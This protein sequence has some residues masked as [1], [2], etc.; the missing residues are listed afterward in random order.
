LKKLLG[1]QE[2]IQSLPQQAQRFASE[3]KESWNRGFQAK[4]DAWKAKCETAA[5]RRRSAEDL[6][7]TPVRIPELLRKEECVRLHIH[8]SLRAEMS[9][10]SSA[11]E[12]SFR[13][14]EGRIAAANKISREISSVSSLSEWLFAASSQPYST[15]ENDSFIHPSIIV[16]DRKAGT[17]IPLT[18]EAVEA[19]PARLLISG[20][21]GMGKTTFC[22]WSVMERLK[23]LET[24]EGMIV[25]VYVPA[26]QLVHRSLSSFEEFFLFSEQM[27]SLWHNRNSKSIGFRIYIDGLD[28][29]PNAVF[30]QQV[31][32]MAIAET[33]KN[34]QL[35]IIVAA[36]DYV[37]IPALEEFVRVSV[38]KFDDPQLERFIS[39]WFKGDPT[40]ERDFRKQLKLA[41]DL[42]ELMKV[43][44]LG[45]IIVKT[46]QTIKS[47]PSSRV[48]LYG[49]FVGLLAG[50]WDFAK[51]VN[52]GS[53]FGQTPKIAIVTHLAYMLH[54][55]RQR[56]FSKDDFKKSVKHVLPKET[57]A[58]DEILKELGRDGLVVSEGGSWG[59]VHHSFQE[60]L[61][62]SSLMEIGGQKARSVFRRYL[63]GDDWWGEVAKFA[64]ALARDPQITLAYIRKIEDYLVCR[65][66][67][68]IVKPR[69]K[70]LLSS[71]EL[72]FST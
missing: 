9:A 20:A 10:L 70:E 42:R 21:P 34:D 19:I 48:E 44:L 63:S 6:N 7:F 49:M 29:V 37:G 71:L 61:A 60:F 16:R 69:V 53:R 62:A 68:V 39:K 51:L 15:V 41:P 56:E 59:F 52:R 35:F 57:S 36:R 11:F 28:E 24:G 40:G 13:T 26:Y 32:E 8:D 47:L 43:P 45:T 4:W 38:E 50:G 33:K 27:Q 18:S 1:T 65:K 64:V 67:D 23:T 54:D 14:L 5:T 17:S 55:R 22:K 66:Q 30:Q 12:Y 72:A 46:R 31:L 3:L 25:P 2:S 58:A